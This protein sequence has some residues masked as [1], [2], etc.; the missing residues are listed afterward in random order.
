MMPI[1]QF[2]IFCF[3]M[4]QSV[5][6]EQAPSFSRDDLMLSTGRWRR[7]WTFDAHL[8]GLP[9]ESR[10]VLSPVPMSVAICDPVSDDLHGCNML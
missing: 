10:L 7:P 9:E 8:E 1:P 5:A 3:W 2:I 4:P 6:A